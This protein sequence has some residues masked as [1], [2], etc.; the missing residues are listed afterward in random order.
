MFIKIKSFARVRL[1]FDVGFT[2]VTRKPKS[3]PE[4]PVKP[5]WR[6]IYKQLS[7]FHEEHVKIEKNLHD[8][9]ESLDSRSKESMRMRLNDIEPIISLHQKY[10]HVFTG[11]EELK[12]MAKSDPDKDTKDFIKEEEE[13]YKNLLVELEEKAIEFLIPR[14][15]FDDCMSINFEIRPGFFL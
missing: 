4:D 12:E 9:S 10:R 1:G 2:A 6:N 14:D 8:N 15:R 7:L 5:L 11:I 13:N 3:M